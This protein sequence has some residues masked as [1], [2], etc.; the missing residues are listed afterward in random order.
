MHVASR[1]S[2]ITLRKAVGFTLIELLVVVTVIGILI[3]LLLA[4]VQAARESARR[5]QCAN[6]VKQAT[7]AALAH[8]SAISFF[9]TGGWAPKW[10]GHPDRGF[11][12]S[13]PGGWIYNVLPFIEQQALHD[14]GASGTG[15]AI[16]D[17]NAQRITTP[18]A[19]FNCPTR[20]PAAL[21]PLVPTTVLLLINKPQVAARSDY[22]INGGDW[23]V[24]WDDISAAPKD[25]AEGDSP[26]FD[27]RDREMSPQTGISYKRSQVKMSDIT[28]GTSNTFLI[29]E[30][31]MHCGRYGNYFDGADTGDKQPMYCGSPT[32]LIRS[33]GLL[34][35]TSIKIGTVTYTNLPRQDTIMAQT[36]DG[37]LFGSAHANAMNMSF[38][39]GSVRSIDYSIDAE[40]FRRLGNRQD[41]DPLDSS[42]F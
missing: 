19:G 28:D 33:T 13:Q 4:G 20:R 34:G 17:A 37:Q 26:S 3:M 35:K 39:D 5:A 41:G 6:N 36:N 16:E 14:L 32:D 2:G 40:V 29:G 24:L 12:R 10:L 23:L 25:L 1:E 8:E 9:P 7:A 30:K 15:T 11:G 38:C 27:W 31:F 21:Y 22:A 18:L 42:Q